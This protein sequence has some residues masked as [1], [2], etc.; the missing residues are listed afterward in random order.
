MSS[1]LILGLALAAIVIILIVTLG[2][3][4]KKKEKKELLK[5]L[6]E[7]VQKENSVITKKE[8]CN[9]AFI[10]I[11]KE[12]N[13]LFFVKKAGAADSQIVVDLKEIKRSKVSVVSKT[14][15]RKS[16]SQKI[17]EKIMLQLEANKSNTPPIELCI[18]D[19]EIDGLILA[20]ELQMAEEWDTV[21]NEQI[22]DN[23]L[24]A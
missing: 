7:L 20:D 6:N 21:I 14:F 1:F 8:Y 19:S 10:A 16:D 23:M 4:K 3:S 22:R 17:I 9:K 2:G 13:K 24:K 12:S 15:E 11:S 18:Y 5:T